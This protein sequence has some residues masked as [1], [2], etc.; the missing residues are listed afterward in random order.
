MKRKAGSY[1]GGHTLVPR[2][3]AKKSTTPIVQRQLARESMA[4]LKE[5]PIARAP[6]PGE[7]DADL[8]RLREIGPFKVAARHKQKIRGPW[9]F[10]RS[11]MRKS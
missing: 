9:K 4:R 8:A 11:R 5:Q 10:C 1:L 3:W 6:I 2:S 7:R